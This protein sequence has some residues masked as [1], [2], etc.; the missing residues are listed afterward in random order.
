MASGY[1]LKSGSVLQV[2]AL[3]AQLQAAQ[4]AA[5]QATARAEILDKDLEEAHLALVATDH[6]HGAV[7]LSRELA[8]STNE[9]QCLMVCSAPTALS[10]QASHSLSIEPPSSFVFCEAR[11]LLY[12][13]RPSWR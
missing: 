10:L 6:N 5:A 3:E 4:V 1:V 11:T 8:Q 12:R 2:S 7:D 9:L 13:C